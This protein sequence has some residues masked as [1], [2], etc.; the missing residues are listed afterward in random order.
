GLD[1]TV[2]GLDC[3]FD[4]P[5]GI[6]YRA[7][8]TVGCPASA[9]D[10]GD[11]ALDATPHSFRAPSSSIS[12]LHRDFNRTGWLLAGLARPSTPSPSLFA[13]LASLIDPLASLIDA[14]ASLFD[15][16]A[17][18]FEILASTFDQLVPTFDLLA[19]TVDPAR[20]S[21]GRPGRPLKSPPE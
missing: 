4:H 8:R 17:S 15:A 1:P 18:T 13:P 7:R 14:L 3:A 10:Q 21:F 2:G 9:V 19:S 16:L 20:P 11:C 6:V 12:G 5:R